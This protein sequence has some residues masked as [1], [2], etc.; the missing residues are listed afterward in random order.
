MTNSISY[1]QITKQ[2]RLFKCSTNEQ[3]LDYNEKNFLADGRVCQI[4]RS[5]HRREDNS[6]IDLQK[7]RWGCMDCM[8]L[9]QIRDRWLALVDVVKN[10]QVS[11]TEGNS[12]S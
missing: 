9:I 7:V 5:W 6:K 8:N 2:Y 3:M 1:G 4:G 10:R 11:P 12:T